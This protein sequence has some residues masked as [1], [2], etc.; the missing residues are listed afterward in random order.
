[1][2]KRARGHEV[3]PCNSH[4]YVQKRRIRK[5][6]EKGTAG[7]SHAQMCKRSRGWAQSLPFF[8]SKNE[9]YKTKSVYVF[10]TQHYGEICAHI[11]F[12]CAKMRKRKE[13]C[14][15]I[16]RENRNPAFVLP[17]FWKNWLENK[18]Y[19]LENRKF[20]RT[21]YLYLWGERLPDM[22]NCMGTI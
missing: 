20:E 2:H 7:K 15:S 8:M 16:L 1:M 17:F 10:D 14:A 6:R 19:F 21:F 5:N 13:E 22:Q 3:E 9:R 11:F 4:F 12:F 18:G